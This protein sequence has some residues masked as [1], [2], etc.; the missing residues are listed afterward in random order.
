[1]SAR[2]H[3]LK[4]QRSVYDRLQ[5]YARSFIGDLGPELKKY[6]AEYQRDFH[7]FKSVATK[8]D[9]LAS[10]QKSDLVF[11]G[12]Y[13]TLSQ[14]QRTVIRLLR[15]S[16][17]TL[18]EQ[19]R[20]VILALEM[21]SHEHNVHINKYLAGM[22]D[23]TEFLRAVSFR[24]NWGF[25]WENYRAL[26]IFAKNHGIQIVGINRPGGPRRIS[27]R[28]RDRHMARVLTQLTAAQP[29][30]LIFA[31]IGDL[32]LASGHLPHHLNLALKKR[33][34]RRKRLIIHQ[35]NDRYY[36]Q[37]AERGL[38]HRVDVVKMNESVYCVMNTPPWVKLQSHLKWVEELNEGPP[39]GRRFSDLDFTEDFIEIV[40]VVESF[41]GFKKRRDDDLNLSVSSARRPFVRTS[42][43][44]PEIFSAAEIKLSDTFRATFKSHFVP[45]LNLVA[46]NDF[47]LNQAATQASIYLF[48][49]KSGFC[50]IFQR[51]YD[52]FYPFVWVEAFGFFGSKMINHKRKCN[53]PADLKRLA[54]DEA[55]SAT[56]SNLDNQRIARWVLRHLEWEKSDRVRRGGI[57]LLL[58]KSQ[59]SPERILFY[60]K[61]AK[62]LGQLLGQAFYSAVIESK[63]KRSEIKNLFIN[64]AVILPGPSKALYL[65]WARR[66]DTFEFRQ[67]VKTEKL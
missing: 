12:D 39:A 17:S 58:P 27:L 64:P 30:T 34:I 41:L 67:I 62:I 53:G 16:L 9:L 24:R 48:C 46:L 33:G 38:E 19:T 14:A 63:V 42:S 52:D 50:R 20:P 61:A 35:N 26:F 44:A 40:D 6:F 3:L 57:S 51:P 54:A 1:M 55:I 21:V 31:L 66:L 2:T 5:V 28:Q 10:L 18:R 60:Y 43:L 59:I 23:E 56:A 49:L 15:D 11:C 45:V 4:L 36:W 29:R 32:H 25:N 8:E 47:N 37:L 13:H 7:H 65:A 22:L